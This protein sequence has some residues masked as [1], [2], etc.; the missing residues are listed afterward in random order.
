MYYEYVH[1]I[2]TYT[3]YTHITNSYTHGHYEYI[4][5]LFYIIAHLMYIH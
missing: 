5:I 4:L 2:N 3:T 1:I